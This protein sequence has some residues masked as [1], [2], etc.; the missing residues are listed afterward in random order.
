MPLSEAVPSVCDPERNV[1]EPVAAPPYWLVTVAVKVTDWLVAA[2]FSDDAIE[3]VVVAV[4]TAWLTGAD[5]LALKLAEPWYMA[6]IECVPAAS[7]ETEMNA[8]PLA[9]VALPSVV[10][11]EASE[12]ITV[13]LG[14]P[15]VEV[16]AAVRVMLSPKVDGLSE[17]TSEVVV[18]A[19]FTT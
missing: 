12:K 11:V 16:T 7:D 9:N 8:L 15:D 13:P 4:F 5:V 2:G 3:V 1:T 10:E 18:V 6:V 17:E 19:R 14:V